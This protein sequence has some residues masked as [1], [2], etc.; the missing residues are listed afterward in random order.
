M[1]LRLKE[2]MDK[3]G[4]TYT[5]LAA[6]L[7]YNESTIRYWIRVNSIPSDVVLKITEE[8]QWSPNQLFGYQ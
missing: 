7:G 6:K 5:E 3:E 4:M 8:M 2:L 1:K